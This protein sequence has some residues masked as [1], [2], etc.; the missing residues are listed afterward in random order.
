MWLL[1]ETRR[2]LGGSLTA[3]HLGR[4]G[5]VVPGPVDS[6]LDRYRAVHRA[7][8]AGL[9]VAAHDP[10]EGGLAVAL[11][12][13][14]LAGRLGLD[15]DV[16]AEDVPADRASDGLDALEWLGSESNGRLLLVAAPADE[17]ALTDALA[18]LPLQPLGTMTPGDRLRVRYGGSAVVDLGL[19]ELVAAWHGAPRRAGGTP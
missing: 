10:S 7:I 17:A 6:P 1:G 4:E 8:A 16:P 12:E 19:D 13:L 18:G 14:C 11:A 9:V 5:G 15:V 3:E 2:E